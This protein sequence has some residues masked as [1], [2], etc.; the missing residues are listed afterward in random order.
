M[1]AAGEELLHRRVHT[2]KL[3][4]TE[5][6]TQ[7]SLYT[8][9]FLHTEAF[10]QREI[11][12][13]RSFFAQKLFHREIFTLRRFCT[14]TRLHRGAFTHRSFYTE[15]W[16]Y[17]QT[18]WHTEAFTQRSLCTEA[19]T[20]KG[21]YTQ[22]LLH[23]DA[24]THSESFNPQALY[25]QSFFS[26]RSFYTSMNKIK[27]AYGI[28]VWS[29]SSS[30]NSFQAHPAMTSGEV[31]RRSRRWASALNIFR[32]STF[33]P[34]HRDHRPSHHSSPHSNRWDT[35]GHTWSPQPGP[36]AVPMR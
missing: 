31:I 15:K 5:A 4:R 20:H 16:L 33:C 3:L 30:F 34:R 9:W 28:Y 2:Q 8:D 32:K 24:V 7:R 6:F 1:N 10:P 22:K 35:P 36:K 19:F 11:L 21:V 12:T 25:R 13:Q 14:Q 18:R 29:S 27:K 26:H 23:T 17:T